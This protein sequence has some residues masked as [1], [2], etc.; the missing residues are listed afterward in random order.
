M[1]ANIL[2]ALTGSG[3]LTSTR[4]SLGGYALARDAARI[5]LAELVEALDGPI[6]LMDC[7]GT[8]T[9]CGMQNG[10]PMHS[11]IQRVHEKF[12]EFMASYTLADIFTEAEPRR[13]AHAAPSA[14][15]AAPGT[16]HGASGAPRSAFS[17]PLGS[18]VPSV[19][20]SSPESGTSHET[21][22]LPR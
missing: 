2:K 8:Q 9:S 18:S 12:R 19:T 21:A 13:T 1:V 20:A 16:A 3:I 17:L 22:Y 7:T 6:G 10:C 4:G 14:A 11:P 5:T 15:Y